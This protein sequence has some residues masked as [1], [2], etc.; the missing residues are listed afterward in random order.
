MMNME[1]KRT[2][3]NDITNSFMR[4]TLI[5]MTSFKCSL[6]EH[7]LILTFNE[8]MSI[9]DTLI[10]IAIETRMNKRTKLLKI[11]YW[12]YLSNLLLCFLFYSSP[13]PQVFSLDQLMRQGVMGILCNSLISL[14]SKQYHID[15]EFLTLLENGQHLI[16]DMM[17]ILNSKWIKE[18]RMTTW[19][20]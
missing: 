20:Y 18:L 17:L 1:L 3:H 6:A 2:S 8:G 11:L 4:K 7:L 10:I 9:E 16:W 12:L 15:W 14:M 19:K 13:Y 5:P